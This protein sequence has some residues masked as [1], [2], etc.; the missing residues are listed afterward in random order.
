MRNA[1]HGLSSLFC[2]VLVLSIFSLAAGAAEAPSLEERLDAARPEQGWIIEDLMIF[3]ANDLNQFW[4]GQFQG[5]EYQYIPPAIFTPYQGGVQTA[6]GPV[7]AGNAVYCSG[8]HGIYYDIVLLNKILFDVGDYAAAA[9][10]AHEWGHLVQNLIG[11]FGTGLPTVLTEL[12]ADCLTG[13]YTISVDNRGLLDIEDVNEA[14]RILFLFGD[15]LPLMHPNAHGSPQMRHDSFVSGFT[16]GFEGC[17]LDA[18]NNRINGGGGTTMPPTVA[19]PVGNPGDIQSYDFDGDCFL[20]DVE[21]FAATDAW[22]AGQL[23]DIT[24]FAALDAWIGQTSVCLVAAG[25]RQSITLKVDSQRVLFQSNMPTSSM[26]VQVFDSNGRVLFDE[27][28]SGSR[29][30]WNMRD[31]RGNRV[32]SGVYFYRVLIA[33][34]DGSTSFGEIEKMAILN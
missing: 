2:F 20:S 33:N 5:S 31:G 10:I 29:L 22:L 34:S 19:P 11:I 3:V 24:F 21:F 14:A 1:I 15:D 16:Q 30:A 4:A 25:E 7:D 18:V 23:S 27:N 28:M 9:V 6:C 8:D 12:Q 13:I 32:A 17:S 26:R